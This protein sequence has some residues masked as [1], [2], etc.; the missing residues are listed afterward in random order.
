MPIYR[1]KRNYRNKRWK[2][3]ARKK[4]QG[5]PYT[6]RGNLLSRPITCGVVRCVETTIDLQTAMDATGFYILSPT[7][8]PSTFPEWSNW[9]TLFRQFK[10]CGVRT[11]FIVTRNMA[12][13]HHTTAATQV[14]NTNIEMRYYPRAALQVTP[15]TMLEVCNIRQSK[16]CFL[17]SNRERPQKVYAPLL[18]RQV[19]FPDNG[20][21]SD[22]T[23]GPLVRPKFMGCVN[24]ENVLHTNLVYAFQNT[25]YTAPPVGSVLKLRHYIYMTF[26]GQSQ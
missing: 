21:S 12:D 18:I 22:N 19:V 23:T 26:K 6:R 5:A 17:Y 3:R 24:G 10:M 13:G 16:S 15:A 20:N 1:R 4:P 7:F 14:L 8:R 25:T 11:E 9:A 2:R